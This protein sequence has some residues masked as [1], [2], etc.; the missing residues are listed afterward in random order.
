MYISEEYHLNLDAV[1]FCLIE[2]AV[3]AF[4]VKDENSQKILNSIKKEFTYLYIKNADKEE[5]IK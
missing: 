4:N 2:Q 1:E 5:Q 3:I